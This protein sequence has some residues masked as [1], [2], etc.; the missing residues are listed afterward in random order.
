MKMAVFKRRRQST[1]TPRRRVRRKTYTRK[2]FRVPRPRKMSNNYLSVKRSF[3]AGIVSPSTASTPGF[4]SFLAPSLNSAG[5]LFN[6]TLTGLPNVGEYSSL[7]DTYKLSAIKYRLVPRTGPF[8]QD[9]TIP[10]TGTTF[11]DKPNISI[12]YDPKNTL[13]FAGTYSPTTYNVFT[14]LGNVKRFRG[15]RD[16]NIYMKPLIQEQYGSG[17]IRYMKPRF[18]AM[19]AAGLAMP[20]RGTM[21]FFHQNAWTSTSLPSFDVYVTYYMQFRGQR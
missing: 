15:D 7:F 19:D 12:L 1:A 6:T 14:E 5:L 20:H 4:W 13:A 10:S 2:N 11:L 21:V 17:A 3:Y 8:S 9:Q 18:T 16:I